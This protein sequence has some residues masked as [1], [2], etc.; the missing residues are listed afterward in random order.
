MIGDGSTGKQEQNSR[1]L[2]VRCTECGSSSGRRWWGWRAYRTDEL[3]LGEPP[4]LAFYCPTC[5]EREFG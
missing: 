4:P 2:A 5:A 3:D 1:A